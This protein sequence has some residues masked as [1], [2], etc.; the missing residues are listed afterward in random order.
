MVRILQSLIRSTASIMNFCNTGLA[1]PADFKHMARYTQFICWLQGGNAHNCRLRPIYVCLGRETECMCLQVRGAFM[2]WLA[3]HGWQLVV[4]GVDCFHACVS[5]RARRW[6]DLTGEVG[7][8]WDP[9]L[10]T[11]STILKLITPARAYTHTHTQ[12]KP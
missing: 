11:I 3:L 1:Q 7:R 10:S 5:E 4:G 2:C 8:R 9:N 12:L 6:G